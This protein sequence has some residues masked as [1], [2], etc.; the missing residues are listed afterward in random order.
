MPEDN[1]FESWCVSHRCIGVSV[2]Y[3]LAPETSYPG[4]LDDCYAGLRWVY[5]HAEELGVDLN[6]HIEFVAGA[7]RERSNE[8]GFAPREA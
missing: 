1:R 5:D 6:E 7:L 2:D 3:R 4:P 8:L